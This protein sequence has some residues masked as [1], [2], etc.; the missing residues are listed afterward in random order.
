MSDAPD[1]DKLQALG[2]RI[3]S[4]AKT[5]ETEDRERSHVESVSDGWRMVIELVVGIAMGFGIGYGLDYLFGTI[6][7]FLMLFT[8][9]GFAGGVRAMM[10]T[11]AEIQ[12]KDAA[13]TK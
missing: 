10:R 1:P 2:D 9:V 4:L 3:E 6:P 8:L 13:R 7:V 11:A 12:K 5:K